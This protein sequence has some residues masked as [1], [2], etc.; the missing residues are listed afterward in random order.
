MTKSQN[1]RKK[2]RSHH[3]DEEDGDY[4]NYKDKSFE[5]RKE[6][7]VFSPGNIKRHIDVLLV[8]PDDGDIAQ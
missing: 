6:R 2:N 8:K 3:S 1:N 5:H 4:V 7:R